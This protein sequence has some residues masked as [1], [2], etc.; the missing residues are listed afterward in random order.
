[1]SSVFAEDCESLLDEETLENYEQF[2]KGKIIIHSYVVSYDYIYCFYLKNELYAIKEG[3]VVDPSL[4]QIIS[5]IFGDDG[6]SRTFELNM[7][8]IIE[9]LNKGK[10]LCIN[11]ANKDRFKFESGEYYLNDKITDKNTV[12]TR[13]LTETIEEENKYRFV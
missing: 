9:N 12:I 8:E 6:I 5:G 7:N 4:E 1:M 11:N 10:I 2:K 3:S 13:F